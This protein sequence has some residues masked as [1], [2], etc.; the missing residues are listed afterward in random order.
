M[1]IDHRTSF[2]SLITCL[3]YFLHVTFYDPEGTDK[4]FWSAWPSESQSTDELDES[5]FFVFLQYN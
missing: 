2:K 5:S 1:Q 4:L 3:I